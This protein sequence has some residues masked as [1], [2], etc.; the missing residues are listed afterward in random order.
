MVAYLALLTDTY[1]PTATSAKGSAWIKQHER[2]TIT[3][4]PVRQERSLIGIGARNTSS[5]P[6]MG[7]TIT[8]PSAP[9]D[10]GAILLGGGVTLA[11]TTIVQL[12]MVPHVIARIRGRERWEQRVLDLAMLLED[13]L[14]RA[15]DQ[16]RRASSDVRLFGRLLGDETYDQAKVQAAVS[17]ARTDSDE[18]NRSVGEQMARLQKLT[19]QAKQMNSDAT[20]WDEL[21]LSRSHLQAAVLAAGNDRPAPKMNDEQLEK[22]WDGVDQ[23][24]AQMLDKVNEVA[25]PVPMKPPPPQR[26]RQADQLVKGWRGRSAPP[27]LT[28]EPSEPAQAQHR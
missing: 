21:S 25:L 8:L 11:A 10:V 14:P 19:V 2:P 26:L 9:V 22:A 12:Y 15:L 6:G 3:W 23:A 18:A 7:A 1:P 5:R 4:Q 20:Y 17:E 13:E 16:W 28:S 27:L 24:R